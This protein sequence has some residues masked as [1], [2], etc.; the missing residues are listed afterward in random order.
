MKFK[1]YIILLLGI[2]IWGV[3]GAVIEDY[4]I[5]VEPAYWSLYGFIWGV[6]CMIV[7]IKN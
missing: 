5:I 1:K 2:L 4:K 3:L 7:I 6:I